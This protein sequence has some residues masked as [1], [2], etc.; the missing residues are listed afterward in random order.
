MSIPQV[1]LDELKTIEPDAQLSGKL[2]KISSSSGRRYFAKIGNPSEAEQY[3]GEVE[4]LKAI[5]AAAPG[6]APQVLAFGV[7]ETGKPHFA[8]EYKDLRSLSSSEKAATVLAQRLATGL[9]AYQSGE[10]FGFHVPTYCGTTRLKNGWYSRWDECFSALIGE[11]L[12]KLGSRYSGL[13]KNGEEIRHRVIPKLLGK[14]DIQPVLLHGDLWSGNVGVDNVTGN[15]IIYDP[16]SYYGHNEADLAIGRMFGG[17][18][19]SFYS[20]YHSQLPKTEPVDEYN[21][22]AELYELFHYLNH[23]VLFSGS[24][25]HEAQAKMDLLLS[26]CE[27]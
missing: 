2:P 5:A 20:T 17:F 11:L 9:H 22:R 14:L 24:Y 6:L 23:T 13:K 3:T 19:D 1:I 4:S 18:P 8:S 27:E 10:G 26:Q 16:A 7:G 15:P 12:D 21:L 25:A